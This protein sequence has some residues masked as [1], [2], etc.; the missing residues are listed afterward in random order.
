MNKSVIMQPN[1]EAIRAKTMKKIFI[2]LIPY[3]FFLY[4]LSYLDRVNISYVALD[5]TKAFGL[6]ATQFGLIAGIFFL[7]YTIFEVPSN[8]LMHKIGAKVWIA[9]IMVTWGIVVVLT[10]WVQ[11]IGQLYILRFLLG[12]FEAGFFPGVILYLTY[13]FP[14]KERA[15]AF[16]L[17]ISALVVAN[18]VGAPLTT[19]LMDNISWFGMPGWRW[20]FFIQGAPAII[21]G[22]V[23]YFYLPNR[24]EE[25]KWL[26]EE[27][28][29]W[30]KGELN[31]GL[32]STGKG[33]SL[34]IKEAFFDPKIRRMA[35]VF[36][37]VLTGLY[38]VGFWMPTII[39]AYSDN[40]SNTKVG[41][42]V[43]IPYIASFIAMIL[44]ARN[45]DRLRERKF[46]T[47]LPPLLGAVSLAACGFT[48]HLYLSIALLTVASVGIN[49]FYAPFWSLTSNFMKSS[50]APVAIAFIISMG[51]I[52]GFVAPYGIGSIIDIFGSAKI[53]LFLM[54]G[55]LFL[56]T[57]AVLTIKGEDIEEKVEGKEEDALL[58]NELTEASQKI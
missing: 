33:E 30:L 58:M 15:R 52:A 29:A 48:E 32:A 50:T 55:M 40:L 26:N 44:W 24:P 47:A 36:F 9:R 53:G 27:E 8:I 22:V 11:S 7:S 49:S 54:A 28:K 6:T 2:R 17:F 34:S 41:L 18:M 1:T 12:V 38:G 35:F 14:A 13:W 42:L 16:A 19:W 57:M 39:Q 21:F 4:F 23:T 46:H 20:V 25:A 45:S 3:L 31:N 37:A 43:M 5:M 51:N 10:T 56:A